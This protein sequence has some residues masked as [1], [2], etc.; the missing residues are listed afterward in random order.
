MNDVGNSILFGM[1]NESLY[2][3]IDAI[4]RKPPANLDDRA[5]KLVALLTAKLEARRQGLES[6]VDE[7]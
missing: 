7:N 4:F 2:E 3:S 5:K 6:K 1:R